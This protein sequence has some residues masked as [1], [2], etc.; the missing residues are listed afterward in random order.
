[1]NLI[2]WLTRLRDRHLEGA[3]GGIY[4]V[5][6]SHP[7]VLQAAMNLAV[8]HGRVLL[9]EATANQVNQYGGY[10]GMTPPAYVAH[11]HR[12]ADAA[13]LPAGRLIIGA[14]HLGPHAWKHETAAAAMDKAVVLA[15][16][17]VSAGFRKIHLD[18]GMCCADDSGGRLDPQTAA[19]RAVVLCRAAENAAA[20]H[21]EWHRPLYVIGY[22][23]PPPGGG[24]LDPDQVD[25]TGPSELMD[26]LNIYEHAFRRGGLASAWQRVAAVVVQPGVE[27]GDLCVALYR[28]PLAAH[29]SACHARLPGIMTFEIHAADYQ[30]PQALRDMVRDHFIL[31][32]VGPCLT[33]TLRETLYALAH[34]E[35]ALPQAREPS[36]LP[37]VM[38]DLMLRQP[39]YWR[40]YHKGSDSQARFLRHFGLRDRMRYYWN[41]PEAR[42]AVSRLLANLS[43][44]IP[45]TLL[46]QYLPDLYSDLTSAAETAGQP[47]LNDPRELI[48]RRVQMALQPYDD[49]WDLQP[50]GLDGSHS[51]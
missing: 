5:C 36:R 39:Q 50:Q 28:S 6:S 1:M 41:Y 29:L 22:E 33:F 37:Q 8:R 43:R 24:L 30:S 31:I 25:L 19:N 44:P 35:E 42:A 23:V 3:V 38:E 51:I 49:V 12:L 32:K 15:R 7:M 11:L 34:I 40:S 9:V 45:R 4:A 27:F 46:H 16:Q 2:N 26:T 47:D 14:D 20:G 10:T 13:G 18:T 21:D 17:C 48:F